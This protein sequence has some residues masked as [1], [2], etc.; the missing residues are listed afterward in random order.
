MLPRETLKT[1]SESCY[2]FVAFSVKSVNAI[3]PNDKK[4]NCFVW[5]H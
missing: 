1:T 3:E 2:G 4:K 5:A